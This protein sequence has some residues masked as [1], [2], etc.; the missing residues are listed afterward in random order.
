M[1]TKTLTALGR[2]TFVVMSLC[3]LWCIQNQKP[4]V[5]NYY[6]VA[7]SSL[8]KTVAHIPPSE[9]PD[10]IRV[11]VDFVNDVAV[12]M[13]TDNH[14][15]LE[16]GDKVKTIDGAEGVV[17]AIMAQGFLAKFDAESIY[18]GLSG[19]VVTGNGETVGYVSSVK[20]GDFL[21]CIWR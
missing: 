1:L 10:A 8:F 6:G 7:D 21:Y 20:D 19:T 16:E 9:I 13:W 3:A 15:D 5:V 4:E 11:Y 2:V 18:A 12:Y 17:T 14:P